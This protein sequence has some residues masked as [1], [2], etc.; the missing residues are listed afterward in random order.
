VLALADFSAAEDGVLPLSARPSG[1]LVISL[2]KDARFLSIVI[3]A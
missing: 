1:S 3:R 2:G